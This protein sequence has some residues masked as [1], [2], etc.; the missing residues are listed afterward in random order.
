[1]TTG[2][3]VPAPHGARQR[4]LFSGLKS[5]GKLSP[6]A[7]PAPPGPRKRVQSPAASGNG[8]EAAATKMTAIGREKVEFM[9]APD[10]DP[11]CSG[12]RMVIVQA[13]LTSENGASYSHVSGVS[14][15]PSNPR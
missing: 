10:C 7:I 5:V 1:M 9:V 14:C 13:D 8:S 11:N 3:D 4:S 15:S 6:V 12:W 2:D